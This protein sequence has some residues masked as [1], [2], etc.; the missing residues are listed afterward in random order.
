MD[1]TSEVTDRSSEST[2]R[3]RLPLVVAVIAPVVLAVD[4]ATKTWAV[5]A[6]TDSGPV[7]LVGSL[8]RLN[9]TRNP[10]AAFSFATGMTWIFTIIATAVAITIVRVSRKLGSL[11]WAV[12]LGLLLGGAL[13]NLADRVFRWP[14][15]AVGHVVDFLELPH[16]PVF[17]VA[18]SSIFCAAVLI[19]LLGFR[20]IGIDGSRTGA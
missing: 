12:A 7:E 11:G 18:D 15:F 19:G 6:L 9:L 16:W 8:L 4:Q 14:G 3:G 1:D 13:G 5:A 10:G 20:G 17:N 2:A